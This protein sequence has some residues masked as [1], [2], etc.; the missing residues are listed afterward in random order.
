ML[1]KPK[2]FKQQLIQVEIDEQELREICVQ[3]ITEMVKQVD[4]EYVF[5][6]S[7]ELLK[8]TCMSWNTIQDNFFF[9]ERFPKR[10]IG[11]KWYYP[12]RETRQF[13]ET[14]I[15]EQKRI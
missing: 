10:K 3:K 14:W 11:G 13:L 5:W 2:A 6:D 4:T 12:V 8:R 1:N 9:D 7:Q 15:S